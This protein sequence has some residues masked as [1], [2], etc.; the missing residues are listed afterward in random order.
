M[1]KYEV[2]FIVRPDLEEANIKEVAQKMSVVL[3]DNQAKVLE[4]KDMG[5]RDLAYEINKYHKGYYFLITIEA[6]NDAAISEFDRL[7][8]ISEDIIR[9]LIVRVDN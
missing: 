4:V 2:M 8:L 1:R 7:A 6:E 9:H 3:S 5:Q